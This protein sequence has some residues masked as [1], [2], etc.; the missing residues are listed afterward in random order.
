MLLQCGFRQR[1]LGK[2]IDL[3]SLNS[4]THN[5]HKPGL[6]NCQGNVTSSQL[7]FVTRRACSPQVDDH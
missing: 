6:T 5:I 4:N 3:I 7:W 1:K 2:L